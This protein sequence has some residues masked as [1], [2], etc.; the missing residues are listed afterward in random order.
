MFTLR[1]APEH[2]VIHSMYPSYLENSL[3]FILLYTDVKKRISAGN[4]STQA[5][6]RTVQGQPDQ[7]NSS[8][9]TEVETLPQ[10][11]KTKFLCLNLLLSLI[12]TFTSTH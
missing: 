1:W 7:H 9:Q 3:H 4:P 2:L 5:E 8:R 12:Y 10:K 6:G 11:T